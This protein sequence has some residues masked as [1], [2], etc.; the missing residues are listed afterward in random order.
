MGPVNMTGIN[1]YFVSNVGEN[2]S[3]IAAWFFR[4]LSD[5]EFHFL[6]HISDCNYVIK[7]YSKIGCN[8]LSRYA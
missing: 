4:Q 7:G 5:K 2:S 8:A 3:C 6:D 1:N